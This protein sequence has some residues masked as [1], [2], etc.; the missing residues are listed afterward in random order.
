MARAGFDSANYQLPNHSGNA[1]SYYTRAK[2]ADL[3]WVQAF[4]ADCIYAI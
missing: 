1:L 2:S 3:Q 4:S